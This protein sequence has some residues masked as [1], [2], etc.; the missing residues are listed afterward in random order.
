MSGTNLSHN[1]P[2][3]RWAILS[4]LIVFGVLLSACGGTTQ[5]KTYTIG[6][7][8]YVPALDQVLDGFKARMAELGY[9]EGQNVKYIYRGVTAPDPQ[10]L[11]REVKSLLD[12]Q[13]DM[14]LTM[15]T[16]PTLTAKQAVTGTDVPVVFAPVINPVEEG[17]VASINRPGGNVTGV[18]NGHTIAKALEW[19]NRIAPKATKVH[20]LYHPEDEVARTSIKP[21]PE[22]ASRLGIELVLDET[23]SS[24][25]ALA[26]IKALPKDAALFFVASPKLDPVTSLIDAAVQRGLPVGSASN[27]HVQAGAVVS[28]AANFSAMGA[29][30][31]RMADQIL[32][33]TKPADMPV[34]T[35]EFF[36]NINLKSAQIIGLDIPDTI[37]VQANTVIR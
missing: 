5:P 19:L 31:A 17:A 36:L 26:T 15:G 34:E 27:G 28:Y 2:R 37:L 12:Q 30:A 4:W 9:V 25:E 24:E 13:V 16:L 20:I 8:N 33:G 29:Q 1:Q 23:R 10:T 11:D 18:Q 3:T 14:F 6:V 22:V 32:K 21:L 35:A 7:V